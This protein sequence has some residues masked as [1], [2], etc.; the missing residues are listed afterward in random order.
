MTKEN[1]FILELCKFIE[2]DKEKI[3]DFLMNQVGS[4][5]KPLAFPYVLGQLCW[6]RMGGTAYF[7]LRECGLLENVNREFES[8][9]KTVYDSGIVK[10]QS[11][12]KALCELAEILNDVSFPY[13]LLKGAYLVSVYPEGLRTSNDIDLLIGQS[14]LTEAEKRLKSA[15][16]LQGYI[17]NGAFTPASRAEII[18][19]RMNRGEVVP[20]IKEIGLPGMPYLEIDVNFSLDFQASQTTDVVD[21]ILRDAQPLIETDQ[22]NLHT[23]SPADFLLHLC[24]HLYKEASTYAWV[25]MER[26]L[27]LYKFVD[28]YL[29]LWKWTDE[30][31]YDSLAN[32]T[33]EHQQQKAV[34]Y[35]MVRTRELFEIQN[36]MLD[37]LLDSVK[38]EEPFFMN[39]IVQ[40]AAKKTFRYDMAYIDWLFTSGRKEKL[41]EVENARAQNPGEA[42]YLLRAGRMR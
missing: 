19:S 41:N 4:F 16:F 17:N 3:A 29:L 34:Y 35:S 24:C 6:H 25:E 33:Q 5:A 36:E 18:S 15:G 28:L 1:A 7:V 8:T 22:G 2:P 10:S 21:A 38:P 12:K 26:D 14:D 27:S 30:S 20:F 9:L 32:R 40:P 11:F 37:K 13:A 39:E 31:I 42:D 23:L